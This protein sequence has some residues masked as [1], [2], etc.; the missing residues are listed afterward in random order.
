MFISLRGSRETTHLEP[1][2]VIRYQVPVLTF[3]ALH[4]YDPLRIRLLGEL[5]R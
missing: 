4:E 2:Q 1:P 3:W 5:V